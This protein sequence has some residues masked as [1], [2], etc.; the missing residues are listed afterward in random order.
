[1][2]WKYKLKLE[3]GRLFIPAV[4]NLSGTGD[5]FHGRQFVHRLGWGRGRGPVPVCDPG[6]GDPWA[7]SFQI[8]QMHMEKGGSGH[9]PESQEREFLA[10]SCHQ[11][12]H[13][14]R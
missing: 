3:R 1:M 10:P 14:F 12:V 6:A 7:V 13:D 2:W 4:L 8:A 11:R 9:K 5:W